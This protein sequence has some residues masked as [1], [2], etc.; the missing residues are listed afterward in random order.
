M[1]VLVDTS[2]WSLAL[3]RRSEALSADEKSMVAELTELIR[4]GRAAIIGLIRQEL[5]SGVKTSEQYEKLRLHLR[6][7]PD[8]SLNEADYED[9][10]R[11]SNVCRAKGIAVFVVDM[12]ICAVASNRS[13][14]IFT[15]DP[16]FKRFATVLALKIHH[17]RT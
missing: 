8:D 7:F 9:A 5:L 3:R 10:A 13:W 14:S 17:P 11:F 4:E 16:D 15:T 6:S 1:K 2:V 12:L